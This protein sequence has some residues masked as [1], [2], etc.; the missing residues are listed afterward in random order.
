MSTMEVTQTATTPEPRSEPPA[1][2]SNASEPW[3]PGRRSAKELLA[4]A[5]EF[6][7]E[8]RRRSWFHVAETFTVLGA[9]WAVTIV[10]PWWWAR[11]AASIVLGVVVV[12]GFILYHDFMHNSLLRGSTV[13]KWIMYAYGVL[14]MTPPN[15]WRQ[16]HNYHHGNTAKIVGS[17]VGSYLMVTTEMWKKMSRAERLGYKVY[18]H[19]LTIVF[20]YFTVFA[21]GM[22]VSSFQRNPKKNWDSLLALVLHAITAVLL[23]VFAG[24]QMFLFA[25]FLPLFVATMV[26]AYLFYAQHDFPEMNVQPRETWEYT[27]AA[28]ESSSYMT[29]GPI[30]HWLTGNIGYHHVHHLNPGIPFYRL[31]EAMAAIPE[32]QHPRGKT[33]LHPR[34]IAACFRAKLWDTT[35][36]RMVGYPDEA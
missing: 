28:L 5:K 8:D 20:A 4:A 19:P 25:Y 16:T 34:D 30:M 2:A 33:S 9:L 10:A 26:G 29:G 31:P 21:Y 7:K 18:R 1:N 14:V 13:G 35:Q 6:G 27:R 17:H 24:W 15:V 12:R 22:C 23:L 36:G 11:L 3:P 32:L